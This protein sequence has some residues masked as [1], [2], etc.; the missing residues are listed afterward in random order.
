MLLPYMQ[1][2][3]RES[4]PAY[5]TPCGRKAPTVG[6]VVEAAVLRLKLGGHR[7]KTVLRHAVIFNNAERGIETAEIMD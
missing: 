4:W 7:A 3:V 1:S 6:V 5:S 2:P